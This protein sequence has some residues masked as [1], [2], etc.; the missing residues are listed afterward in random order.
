V[1]CRILLVVNSEWYFLSHRLSFARALQREGWEVLVAS[2]IERGQDGL[3]RKAGFQ[4]VP[5]GMRRDCLNPAYEARALVDLWRLYRA[6]KPDLVHHITVKPVIYGS[7]AARM[8]GIRA[9]INTI[10]G[11][12]YAFSGKGPGW[13][14]VRV[15]LGGAYRLALHNA[16]VRVIFQ[17]QRDRDFFLAKRMV[18]PEQ[19]RVIKGSGVDAI[20]FTPGPE[21]AGVPVVLYASRMIWDKGVGELVG[22]ARILKAREVSARVVLVGAPDPRSLNSVPREALERWQG[23]GLI[24]WWGPQDNMPDVLQQAAIITLPTYYPEGLPRI[25]L[26]AAAVGRPIVG[27]DTAGCTDIVRNGENGILVPP[28]DQVALADAL[29]LL[30]EDADRRRKMGAAGRRIVLE[31]FTED[32]IIEQ[33][34][35]VYRELVQV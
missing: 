5:F 34:L 17:N 29:G 14:A 7:A 32:Q 26:E 1:K 25:L 18:R 4:F 27:T 24:E 8:L 31:E 3:I 23:E 2:P 6:L 15:I 16:H 11:L 9:V 10:P 21:P 35:E 12:G 22:A 33:T 19:C 13:A 28:R 30:I 20:K